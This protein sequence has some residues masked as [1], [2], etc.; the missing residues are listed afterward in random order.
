MM[1]TCFENELHEFGVDL[2]RTNMR[3]SRAIG[4]AGRTI[5]EIT[6]DPLIASLAADVL[7]IAE[8]SDRERLP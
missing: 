6:V 2:M 5:L 7:V 1:T 4:K 8:F 3:T